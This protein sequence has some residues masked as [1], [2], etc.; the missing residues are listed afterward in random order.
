MTA[1]ATRPALKSIVQVSVFFLFEWRGDKSVIFML[2]PCPKHRYLQSFVPLYNIL[3][4]YVEQ[5]TLSQE[6]MPVATMRKTLVLTA[7]L[8]MPSLCWIAACARSCMNLPSFLPFCT[9][10]LCKDV[11]QGA[12]SQASMP[13][14]TMPKTRLFAAFL[15][16]CTTVQGCGARH[17]VASA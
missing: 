12:L 15:P 7:L 3:C 5:D 2:R 1:P 9:I 13:V 6:T 11:E 17:T 16:C 14:A 10:I 8:L 4:K